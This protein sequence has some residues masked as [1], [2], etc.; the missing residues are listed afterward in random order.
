MLL[1]VMMMT[2]MMFDGSNASGDVFVQAS[3]P[4]SAT[5]FHAQALRFQ[6]VQEDPFDSYNENFGEFLKQ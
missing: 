3:N 1:V 2:T 5:W 4:T 6:D